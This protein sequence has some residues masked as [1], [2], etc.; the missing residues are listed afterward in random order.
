MTTMLDEAP[1]VCAPAA[2]RMGATLP[3]AA[4]TT[5]TAAP[6]GPE[7]PWTRRPA[8]KTGRYV[9]T[10][11]FAKAVV[12]MVRALGKR[13][14]NMDIDELPTLAALAAEADEVLV[15][16]ARQLHDRGYD[17]AGIGR[18]LGVSKQTAWRRYSRKE[19]SDG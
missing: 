13:V 11:K 15:D 12:R 5:V 4:E 6:A 18:A 2:Q 8:N 10:G 1:A 16:A 14:G 7:G 19:T 17:W 9:E 3:A